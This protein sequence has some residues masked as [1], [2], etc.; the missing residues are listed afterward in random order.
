MQ[1]QCAGKGTKLW[2][3]HVGATL[4]INVKVGG[5]LP[6]ITLWINVKVGG[7]LPEIS[8]NVL[9]FFF[10]FLV[11]KN[12]VVNSLTHQPFEKLGEVHCETSVKKCVTGD[13]SH[14]TFRQ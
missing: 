12:L 10:L 1:Y 8:K 9:N 6:E 14:I 7:T 4:W 11:N 2:L 13:V 3:R 5:T